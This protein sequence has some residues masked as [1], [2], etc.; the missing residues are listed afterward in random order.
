M[1]CTP[2]CWTVKAARTARQNRHREVWRGRGV[3]RSREVETHTHIHT[4]TN[5][6]THIH[7]HTH[8]HISFFF[9]FSGR[10]RKSCGCS[11]NL[12]KVV[13]NCRLGNLAHCP[14]LDSSSHTNARTVKKK[15]QQQQKNKSK[16]ECNPKKPPLLLFSLHSLFFS[17]CALSRNG[18]F[19]KNRSRHHKTQQAQLT[20]ASKNNNQQQ[21]P[22]LPSFLHC[23]PNPH[24]LLF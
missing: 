11:S 8:T 18:L 20:L 9:F 15:Q 4:Y 16:G 1:R 5:T 23:H 21:Q 12:V 22:P 10:Q 2:H 24:S 6:S 3:E 14:R 7:T 19:Q 17:L 13:T